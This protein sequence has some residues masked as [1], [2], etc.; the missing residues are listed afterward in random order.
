MRLHLT[1]RDVVGKNLFVP[2]KSLPVLI[3]EV[4]LIMER[5]SWSSVA[6]LSPS[7][8]WFWS[9]ARHSLPLDVSEFSDESLDLV[10]KELLSSRGFDV[11]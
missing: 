6:S 4:L 9:R 2:F 7:P 3:K 8:R 5:S 10:P 11:W 1:D